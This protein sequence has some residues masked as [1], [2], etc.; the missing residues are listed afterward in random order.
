MKTLHIIDH[1]SMGGAQRI[2]EGILHSMPTAALLPLR[3]KGLPH[4]Q[5]NLPDGRFLM[6][7]DGNLLRQMLR[8]WNIPRVIAQMDVQ[9]VHCHLMF[10]W[11]FGLFLYAALPIK[12]R[13][14]FIFHEHDSIKIRRWYY[15]LLARAACRAGTLI[16]V[17]RFIQ[18]EI[19]SHGIPLE[20]IHLLYNYVDLDL[21]VPGEP[22]SPE[23]FGLSLQQ[24]QSKRI[25]GFAGRLVDYKGWRYI[26]EV[27]SRLRSQNIHFLIAGGGPDKRKLQRAIER[28]RLADTVTLTGYIDHMVDF[29][30]LIDILVIASAREAF[31]LVQLEAQA[32]GVPVIV[33]ENQ[34]ALE[35]IGKQSTLIVPYGSIDAMIEKIAY[36]LENQEA[37]DRL[38]QKGMENAQNYGLPAYLQKLSAIYAADPAPEESR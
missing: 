36:L 38:A 3:R 30:H 25:I 26:L 15:P 18:E 19:A 32:C 10:S 29:Y 8:L 11:W 12:H 34:A 37:Y 1:F 27:A 6:K 24:A 4:E 23:Q 14:R 9:I 31:G 35:L 16:A 5:I 7:P 21:F 13:P 17:S 33:F 22:R 2:V 20:R 28:M